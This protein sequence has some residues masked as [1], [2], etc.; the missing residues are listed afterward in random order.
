[1]KYIR[2][3]FK[4]DL[5]PKVFVMFINTLINKSVFGIQLNNKLNCLY[6]HIYIGLLK[7]QEEDILYVKITYWR[8]VCLSCVDKINLRA[9]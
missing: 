4:L 5:G 6:R 3:L 7:N 1:M 2:S 8:S 9:I